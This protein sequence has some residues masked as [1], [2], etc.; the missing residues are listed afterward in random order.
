MYCIV[1]PHNLLYTTEPQIDDPQHSKCDV[2]KSVQSEPFFY[3][4][5]HSE[6]LN[7][8]SQIQSILCSPEESFPLRSRSDSP[9]KNKNKNS[10]L[11][12]LSTG[13]FDANNPKASMLLTWKMLPI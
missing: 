2:D 4:V 3:K 12:G 11:I 6:H 10:L 13:L 8:A 1:L 5:I 7:V 9:P